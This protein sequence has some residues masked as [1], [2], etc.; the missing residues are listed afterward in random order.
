M[1]P[2]ERLTRA[3]RQARTRAALLDAAG[4]EFTE[5]GYRG[6]SVERIAAAA[7]FTRGAF[8]SNF[9]SKG[10]LFAELLQEKAFSLYRD[11]ARAIL[12]GRRTPTVRESG[13]RLA[14]VQR[15][16]EGRWLFRLWLELLAESGRDPGLQ[17]LA[18][19]FWTDTRR[20]T[21]EVVERD[22]AARGAE[23]PV[24]ADRLAT[25]MIALDIGLALQH[26]VDPDAV[27]L[28]AYPELFELLF[29]TLRR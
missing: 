1:S 11:M 12:S 6:A 2:A 19:G 17:R 3:E 28:D 29:E 25:A 21:A 20:L 26:H 13:E 4:R 9:A 16:P 23:P 27:P 8:Y 24:A 22:Y 10:E 14:Q 5:R 7:G 18:A 15:D